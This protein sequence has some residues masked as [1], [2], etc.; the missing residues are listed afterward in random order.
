MESTTRKPRIEVIPPQRKP[1]PD[2]TEQAF[3]EDRALGPVRPPQTTASKRPHPFLYTLSFVPGVT[4]LVALWFYM[5]DDDAPTSHRLAILASFVYL[6][7]P[8]DMFNDLIAPLVGYLDDVAI[9]IGL[10]KFVGS[11]TL[12]PYRKAA[13]AFLRGKPIEE[14]L[15]MTAKD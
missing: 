6:I 7:W 1:L 12:R 13:R 8:G 11:E 10:A 4:S 3:A 15:K 2:P 14:A 9:F 5:L